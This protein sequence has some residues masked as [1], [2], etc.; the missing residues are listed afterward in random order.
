MNN[1]YGSIMSAKLKQNI[2]TNTEKELCYHEKS[3]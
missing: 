3:N 2:L 1:D